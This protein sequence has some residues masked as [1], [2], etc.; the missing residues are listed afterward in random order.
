MFIFGCAGS[1]LLHRLFSS[2]DKEGATL[3]AVH[4][5]LTMVASPV[6]IAQCLVHMGQYLFLGF[7]AQEQQLWCLGLVALW[8]VGSSQIREQTCVSFIAR[9][10]LYH[11]ATREAQEN[12][13]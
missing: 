11:S 10:I 13:S 12:Y 1:S 9:R 8:H 3:V 7:I 5:P 4:R 2:C 6:G